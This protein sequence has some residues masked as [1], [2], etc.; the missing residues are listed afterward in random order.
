MDAP[1]QPAPAPPPAFDRRRLTLLMVPISAFFVLGFVGNWL[2]P[3]LTDRPAL[4][5]AV[6][7][8]TRY[9]LLAIG[10]GITAAPFFLI[11]FTRLVIA[12]PLFYLLGRWYG[13]AGL[14]WM[15]RQSGGPG[16]LGWISWVEKHF[17]RWGLPFIAIMPNQL[18]CLLAGQTKVPP[19]TFLAL[20]LGGTMARLALVWWLG[21]QFK[22]TLEDVVAFVQRYQWWLVGGLFV[23]SMLQS[24][25]RAAR[26]QL[27]SPRRAEDE[28]EAEWRT[29]HPAPDTPAGG[30]TDEETG[31]TGR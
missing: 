2:G 17:P 8:R 10:A 25:R 27:E 26:G 19:R 30:G 23:L 14:R 5:L 28:I 22:D 7:S 1:A 31:T 11:A 6:D 20:N 24:G 21:L 15:E 4:M 3:A 16:S 12:D 18:V 13:D 29:E 9:L